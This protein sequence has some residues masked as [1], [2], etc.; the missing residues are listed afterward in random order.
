M[1]KSNEQLSARMRRE[2]GQNLSVFGVASPGG[3]VGQSRG[4]ALV[5]TLWIVAALTVTVTGL[6]YAVRGEVR[7]VAW[8]REMAAAGAL[9][10]AG[11]VLAARELAGANDRQSGLRRSEVS[12]AQVA[13]GI[14]VVPLT[15]LIDVNSAPEPLLT[16]LIVFA[17]E[18]D[19]SRASQL[20]QRII[21]WR[22]A[23]DDP[24]PSGAE[25]AVYAATGSLFRTRG[26]PFESSE[27]L[28]QVLEID[29][30][31]YE[32]IRPLI[33]V[34]FRGNGRVDPAAAPMPVLRILAAGNE[35]IAA[36]Y[37]GERESRG[38]LADS[39]RFPEA[40]ISRTTSSRYLIEVSVPLS[41]G[42]FLVTR[43]ILDVAS[44]HDGL[45]WET[46]WAER[47]VEAAHNG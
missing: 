14:R 15:G 36:A 6:V 7:T 29:F 19:R 5:A 8:F 25:D 41:N 11:V 24:K 12:F 32:R 39:T 17:G 28:L 45:P 47:V 26:G 43:Q 40:L 35:Q 4:L 37:A 22:D 1:T 34:H 10:D 44:A 42:A 18:V 23:D 3:R 2:I 9:G 38:A 21:D 30:E 20:A 16:D 27:D 33:T 46:L 13:I 31:L